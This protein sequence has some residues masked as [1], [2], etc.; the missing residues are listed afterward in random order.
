MSRINIV[1]IV[2]LLKE[3]YRFNLIHILIATLKDPYSPSHGKQKPRR[4]KIF[5]YNKRSSGGITIP[6]FKLYYVAIE[7]QSWMLFA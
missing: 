1:K 5:L 6:D 2:I 3:I 4:A 7:I